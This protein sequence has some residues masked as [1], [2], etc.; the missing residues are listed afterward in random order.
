MVPVRLA[1]TCGLSDPRAPV[2]V[3]CTTPRSGSEAFCA[4]LRAGGL[5]EAREIAHPMV[6]AGLEQHY[7]VTLQDASLDA[8]V[9]TMREAVGAK[10]PLAIKLFYPEMQEIADSAVMTDAVLIHLE[11]R[12]LRAQTISLL[13]L[14]TT[15]RA[16]DSR[17]QSFRGDVAELDDRTVKIAIAF[18]R[19]Q[20]R[21][22]RKW[23]AGRGHLDVVSEDAFADPQATFTSVKGFLHDARVEFDAEAAAAALAG[24]RKYGQDR[25][26]KAQ[27]ARDYADI[28]ATLGPKEN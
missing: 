17:L 22:W 20:R 11:R 6:Q 27:I 14:W 13:T 1:E 23:L 19:Q 25:E 26:V 24:S 9:A 2:V 5:R 8:A 28:L 10:N 21:Q 15:G 18:L 12:D 3:V 4:A 7:G 16:L